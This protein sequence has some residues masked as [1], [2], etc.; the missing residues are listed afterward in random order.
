MVGTPRLELGTSS[1]SEKRS[2]QL[3]Y[4]PVVDVDFARFDLVDDQIS[5][6]SSRL[7]S[8]QNLRHLSGY[9]FVGPPLREEGGKRAKGS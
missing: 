1:L 5:L 3:S 4:A 2:N 8:P 9:V 7:L 6:A